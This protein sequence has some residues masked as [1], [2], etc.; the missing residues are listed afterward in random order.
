MEQGDRLLFF[1]RADRQC[2][3]HLTAFAGLA[4]L[5]AGGNKA[6]LLGNE[7]KPDYNMHTAVATASEGFCY[8][9]VRAGSFAHINVKVSLLEEEAPNVLTCREPSKWTIPAGSTSFG[10]QLTVAEWTDLSLKF[11]DCQGEFS[12]Q[13]ENE[14]VMLKPDFKDLYILRS[15]YVGQDLQITAKKD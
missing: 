7:T 15:E 4:S 9:L 2:V 1:T 8:A 10:L 11:I 13:S 6:Q 5:T 14:N 12:I 3:F